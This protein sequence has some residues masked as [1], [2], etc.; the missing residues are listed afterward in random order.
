M[1]SGEVAWLIQCPPAL[2][3]VRGE[4]I[5]TTARLVTAVDIPLLA[6]PPTRGG[7]TVDSVR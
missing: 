4:F 6:S 5:A 7:P 2:A 1:R 3:S